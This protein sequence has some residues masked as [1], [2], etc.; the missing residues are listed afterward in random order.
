MVRSSPGDE[1][2]QVR[3]ADEW[4]RAH[5]PRQPRIWA[6]PNGDWAAGAERALQ[7]L[8]YEAGLLFDHRLG[9]VRQNPLRLLR[10]R[11]D[12]DAPLD[13]FRAIVSGAHPFL[14]GRAP[15]PSITV[16]LSLL[17]FESL[18]PNDVLA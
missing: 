14:R 4:L 13:R 2:R 9:S 18:D 1:A 15:G 8:G 10:L 17:Q 16:S 3:L 6:Y 7:E 11:V 5:F 12:A